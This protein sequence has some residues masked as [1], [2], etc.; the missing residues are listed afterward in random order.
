MTRLPLN[1]DLTGTDLLVT[2]GLK[3][4]AYAG[5]IGFF[6]IASLAELAPN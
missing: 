6:F 1:F 3:L 5:S 2:K 4:Q